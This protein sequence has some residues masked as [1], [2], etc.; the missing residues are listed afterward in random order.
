M[1]NVLCLHVEQHCSLLEEGHY[2]YLFFVPFLLCLFLDFFFLT[3]C[4]LVGKQHD[5]RNDDIVFGFVQR[6]I[7]QRG[8]SGEGLPRPPRQP[9]KRAE[10][11]PEPIFINLERLPMYIYIYIYIYILCMHVC[12]HVERKMKEA[13]ENLTKI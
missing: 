1:R 3:L 7:K 9:K 8:R 12:M 5:D 13:F 4:F 11:N 2:R 10:A 6:R